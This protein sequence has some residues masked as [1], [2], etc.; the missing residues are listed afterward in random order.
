VL[1]VSN[2]FQKN[3]ATIGVSIRFPFL[4]MSQRARAAG[5]DAEALKAKKQAEAARDRASEQTLRLQR[6]VTQLQAAHDVAE[7]EYEVAE[8]TLTATQT[9]IDAGTA[10][11]HGLDDARAQLSERFM[12]LQ[13]VTFDL[14]RTQLGLLRST[15]DLEKWAMGTH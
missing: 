14:Q 8:K 12:T 13:D 6:S 1:C 15:G 11:L 7:L 9:R 5:A 2:S 4:N 10:N 3:N